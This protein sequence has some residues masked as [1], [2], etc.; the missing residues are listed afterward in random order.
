MKSP[1]TTTDMIYNIIIRRFSNIMS[2]LHALHCGP[3]VHVLDYSLDVSVL[4]LAAVASSFKSA[5]EKCRP[6]G[7]CGPWKHLPGQ[8]H[9]SGLWKVLG[10][11]DLKKLP[12]VTLCCETEFKDTAEVLAFVKAAKALAADTVDG[13]VAFNKCSFDAD[14][15]EVERLF[16]P[17][18]DEFYCF[19]HQ[20]AQIPFN[21]CKIECTMDV[22][23]GLPDC[24]CPWILMYVW[25]K[26]D[27]DGRQNPLVCCSSLVFPELRLHSL[28]DREENEIDYLDASSPLTELVRAG[29]PLPMFFGV[30]GWLRLLPSKSRSTYRGAKGGCVEAAQPGRCFRGVTWGHEAVVYMVLYGTVY[31]MK[32]HERSA[33]I[34]Q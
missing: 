1:T 24:H 33:V 17:S 27:N 2:C 8:W 12:K 10:L 19:G 23:S 20:I 7:G 9:T 25:V 4:E 18:N 31:L 3:L 22:H 32:Q 14:A 21:G 11:G 29:M 34:L 30:V 28:R 13:H 15:K 5:V 6:I 16:S 26:D